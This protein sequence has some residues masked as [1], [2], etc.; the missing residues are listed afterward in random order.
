MP[1]F[2]HIIFRLG[3]RYL[4]AW[5][6]YCDHHLGFLLLLLTVLHLLFL[7]LIKS[8][9]KHM[10]TGR[11]KQVW[12]IQAFFN[13]QFKHILQFPPPPSS[14]SSTYL[15]ETFTVIT[16]LVSSS[17]FVV[18]SNGTIFGLHLLL[19]IV[20]QGRPFSFWGL[21]TFCN[22]HTLELNIRGS[23]YSAWLQSP[24]ILFVILRYQP[25]GKL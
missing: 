13:L 7:L 17:S 9:D 12:L 10:T 20:D 6:F 1:W 8:L 3:P 2:Q 5:G 11:I 15:H 24:D 4:P 23:F 21:S 16:T 14:A 25:W 19:L 22:V 18:A